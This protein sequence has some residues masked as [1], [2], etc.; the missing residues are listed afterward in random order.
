[1]KRTALQA[2]LFISFTGLLAFIGFAYRQSLREVLM[3]PLVERFWRLRFYWMSL[4]PEMVWGFF[5]LTIIL[6][7]L[8]A[9]PPI[10]RA[11]D[12]SF[13]RQIQPGKGNTYV[14]SVE[15]YTGREGRLEFW[16]REVH[17]MRVERYFARLTVVELKKLILDQLVF[18]DRFETR[19]QAERWIREGG[20]DVPEVIRNLF[21]P[22]P[23]AEPAWWEKR[24]GWLDRWLF[25][26]RQGQ[27]T[28]A[29]RDLDL[30]LDYLEQ[31]P[32]ERG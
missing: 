24:L 8:L 4:D 19:L 22:K 12:Q 13:F 21:D 18:R 16:L 10:Q 31:K 27:L 11:I 9:F 25:S 15:S 32:G 28:L 30:I 14:P 17:Q 7:G 3:E 1:M 29:P 6:I 2:I 23:P 26:R 20:I 5:L